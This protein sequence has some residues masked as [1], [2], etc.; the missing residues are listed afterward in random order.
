LALVGHL[1]ESMAICLE[2]E[3][4]LLASDC[5]FLSNGK[6]PCIFPP[7]V[8]PEVCIT[9]FCNYSGCQNNVPI[10]AIN[11]FGYVCV[12]EPQKICLKPSITPPDRLYKLYRRRLKTA[13]WAS[14][15]RGCT[16]FIDAD[17]PPWTKGV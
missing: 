7:A 16:V 14:V 2:Y 12:C 8:R 4:R 13:S 11:A 1:R 5:I 10:G 6:G 9:T 3:N 15:H 17:M